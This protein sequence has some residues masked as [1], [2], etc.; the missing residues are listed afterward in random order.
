MQLSR[1]LHSLKNYSFLVVWLVSFAPAAV[2]AEERN[3]PKVVVLD[4]PTGDLLR[5]CF[6]TIDFH[7]LVQFEN[8][9]NAA[10]NRRAWSTRD[11]DVLVFRSDQ[12]SIRSQ[13]FRERL[14]TQ[15]IRV[16]DLKKHISIDRALRVRLDTVGPNFWRADLDQITSK[17]LPTLSDR[18]V[19]KPTS[20][21]VSVLHHCVPSSQD[22]NV[23]SVHCPP[24]TI[25]ESGTRQI[26]ANVHTSQGN[27]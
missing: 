7:V 20:K 13:L 6:P 1:S 5:A 19:K 25:I 3:S 10:V 16:V 8:E 18:A 26:V 24:C 17:H 27:E 21:T 14:M 4:H 2:V 12:I 22:D 11:A 15:G 23:P 9:S